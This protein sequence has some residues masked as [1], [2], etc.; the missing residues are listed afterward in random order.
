[1][2]PAMREKEPIVARRLSAATTFDAANAA[3]S[4]P[5]GACVD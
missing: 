3:V 2:V 1:L 4:K 5:G